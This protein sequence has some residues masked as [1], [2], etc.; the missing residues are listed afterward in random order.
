MSKA[1]VVSQLDNYRKDRAPAATVALADMFALKLSTS[2]TLDPEKSDWEVLYEQKV[3]DM[4]RNPSSFKLGELVTATKSKTEVNV[5]AGEELAAL[6]N[7]FRQT[8][9]KMVETEVD[10]TEEGK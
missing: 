6:L 9:K 8:P 10:F 2:H 1:N 7:S 5:S 3:M 4:A